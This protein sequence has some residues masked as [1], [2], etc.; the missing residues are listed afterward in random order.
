MIKNITILI[1]ASVACPSLLAFS[2]K[3]EDLDD[4]MGIFPFFAPSSNAAVDEIHF[5]ARGN[6]PRVVLDKMLQDINLALK[7]PMSPAYGKEETIL[8]VSEG[9]RHHRKSFHHNRHHRKHFQK[10]PLPHRR[11]M[12]RNHFKRPFVFHRNPNSLYT[13]NH[14]QR[15]QLFQPNH[16]SIN[17]IKQNTAVDVN[18]KNSLP[19]PPQHPIKK[20]NKRPDILVMKADTIIP[21][22]GET[23]HSHYNN[24]NTKRNNF[25]HH[26]FIRAL[27]EALAEL[28]FFGRLAV[29]ISGGIIITSVLYSIW[30]FIAFLFGF[31]KS[32]YES[33]EDEDGF[34]VEAKEATNKVMSI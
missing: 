3:Q 10:R 8:I 28:G 23:S 5:T 12:K 2:H 26:K 32:G 7:D 30:S 4:E 17:G 27:S 29:S 22:T 20:F 25:H 15:N 19:P 9:K 24:S 13:E 16:H 11:F 33:L 18:M 6:N 14:H 31:S 34:E 21:E 1:L